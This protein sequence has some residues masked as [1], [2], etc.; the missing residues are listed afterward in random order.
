ML[1]AGGVPSVVRDDDLKGFG[2]RLNGNGS[3][4][5][6]VEYRAGR[7]RGFPVRRVVLGKHGALTPE[8][9]RQLAKDMLARVAG[10]ADPAAER[11]KRKRELTVEQWLR[12][13]IEQHWKPKR[14]ASTAANFEAMIERTLIPAFGSRRLSEL[15]R[16]DIREWHAAQTHR[17]R[18][19]N[20]DLA[21]LR[22]AMSLAVADEMIELNPA[23]GIELHPEKARDRI[24]NERELASLVAA[25]HTAE[26][27]SAAA[28]LFRLLLLSGCRVSEW[29]FA[30]WSWVEFKGGVLRLPDAKA[31][32]RNVPLSSQVLVL[33]ENAP[34]S[35]AFVI[36]NDGGDAPLSRSNVRDA[37][38]T[39]CSTA[40]VSELRIHDLR[41][42]FATLGAGL[43]A[44]ALLLRDA[45]GHRTVAMTSRYVS[46]QGD[47]VRVLADRIG[48][49]ISAK[50]SNS[51]I[52]ID[53][54]TQSE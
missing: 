37:W 35:S 47:P 28:L 27:R 9:A 38:A 23:K 48:D 46:R 16:S 4:S 8:Q 29:L 5:Y 12:C 24:P 34:K 40:G 31:G 36:P 11:T 41:H 10:G 33:L 14:K 26:I 51:P 43:G 22:K 32:A 30:R 3:V 53:S 21:I 7:G 49:I 25:L 20:L 15:R 54:S 6:Y 19:A 17:S 50:A 2:A 44:S 18:Q 52:E 42:N 45:L 39:V 13:C 1:L